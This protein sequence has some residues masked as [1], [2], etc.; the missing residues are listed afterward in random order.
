[1]TLFGVGGTGKTRLAL[2]AARA[3]SAA[4]ADGCWLVELGRVGVPG[5][6]PFAVSSGV[7]M[8]TPDAGD[9]TDALVRRLADRQ[10]LIVIDNCEHVVDAAAAL[11]ERIVAECPRVRVI[12]TSREPLMVRGERVMPVGPL[13]ADDGLALFLDRARAES[14]NLV[15][16]DR[17]LDAAAALCERIDGLPLAIELAAARVRSMTP[18]DLLAGLDER[19]RLL[20]GNRRS[21]TE[22]HQTMRATLDW[23]YSLCELDEQLV[24]DRLSV[25]PSE[26][27]AAAARAVAADEAL[28]PGAVIDAVERLVDRSLLMSETGNDGAIRF[29]ML[30]TMRVYG[31]EHLR[32]AGQSDEVRQRHAHHIADVLDQLTLTLLGPDEAAILRRIEGYLADSV[33]TL[34]WFLEHDQ[35]EHAL[36]LP[37]GLMVTRGRESIT[38]VER[39]HAT[40]EH[41]DLPDSLPRNSTS[42]RPMSPCSASPTTS[43]WCNL[44]RSSHTPIATAS[45]MLSAE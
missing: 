26:F 1:M 15:L 34:D 36:R 27:D 42:P 33:L 35:I 4:F 44:L 23:S 30:E 37:P 25:F 45:S 40:S 19:F 17:Q 16:D 31:R 24:F 39:I 9:V 7:G 11:V 14:P 13:P 2:E 3:S 38:M 21:R 29:R 41:L 28:S 20:V 12:A 5:A 10:V 6:V 22:R 32:D 18:V 8:T 43:S